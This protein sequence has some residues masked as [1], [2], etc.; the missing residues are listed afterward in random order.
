MERHRLSFCNVIKLNDDLAEFIVDE[1]VEF[2]LARVNEY[3]A[4]IEANMRS[5]YLILVNKLNAYTYDFAAQQKVGALPGIKAV[6]FVVYSNTSKMITQIMLS[7]PRD[8]DWDYQFFGNR[9]DALNWLE[10]LRGTV[11]PASAAI[12][13]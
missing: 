9:D 10:N 5:P 8:A 6:A 2:N 13:E 11:A 1:G 4:W 3:H 12:G 7:M